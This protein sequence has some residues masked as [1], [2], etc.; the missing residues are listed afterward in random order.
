MCSNQQY[1]KASPGEN[2]KAASYEAARFSLIKPPM[3]FAT[4]PFGVT[5]F[6]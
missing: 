5:Q 3:I 4:T 2:K 6:L 1:P